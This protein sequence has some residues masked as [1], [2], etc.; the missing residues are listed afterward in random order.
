[1]SGTVH[2][3]PYDAIVIGSGP[4]GLAAA[5]TLAEQGRSVLVIEARNMPGGA[6]ATEALTLPGFWHDTYS[7]VYPAGAASPVF[8]RMPLEQHGLQ[9]V[10]PPVLM[11]HP[12]PDGRAVALYRD[13]Q[14]TA[15]GMEAMQTGDGTRW[16]TFMGPYLTHFAALRDTLLAP[17]PPMRGGLKTLVLLGVPV[18]HVLTTRTGEAV[19]GV[20]A[21]DE[22]VQAGMVI[23]D[24]TP[25]E[26]LRLTGE[27]LAPRYRRR[28]Q[29]YTY[30]AQTVK[31]DWALSAPIPWTAREAR[32]A[33]TVHVGGTTA[34][35]HD[36]IRR[37]L[38]GELPE[39]PFL[40]LGQQSLA[41]PARAPAGTWL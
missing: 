30:G 1:M 23:A 12:L 5:I 22:E 32:Q 20:R 36:S 18:E 28:L 34:D 27:A 10:H 8:A 33:G 26:L 24:V 37:Q 3:G 15:A 39:R 17:F 31:V 19:R 9:W 14:R 38:G 40:L 16:Q 4:N 25:R 7:A 2:R 13:I 41:D 6:V 11:A 35:I 21:G 29:R